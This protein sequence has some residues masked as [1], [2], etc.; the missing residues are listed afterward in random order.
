MNGA[1]ADARRRSSTTRAGRYP[2]SVPPGALVPFV[3]I[4]GG[5]SSARAAASGIALALARALG[6]PCGLAGAA[7]GGAA[8]SLGCV[9]AARRAVAS[10][11][12]RGLPA[13]ASGRLV[14]LADRRGADPTDDV[15][16]HAAALSAELGRAAAAVGAP[17]AAALPFVR[18]AALDRVLAW[19]DA[20][21]VVR[22]ANVSDAMLGQALASL[23][24]LGRPVVAMAPPTR[25]ATA[26]AAGGLQPPAEAVH[27]IAELGLGPGRRGQGRRDA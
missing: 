13:T 11:H 14:W 26:L 16:A 27:A 6:R 8:G 23:A 4:L 2:T 3:A 9:P 18:T 15:P 12:E 7:G 25:L 10:L 17:A 21:V 5:P 20:L 24:A 22:Q 1:A 19:H